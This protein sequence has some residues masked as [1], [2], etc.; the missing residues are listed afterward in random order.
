MQLYSTNDPS[1]RVEFA[2][3]VFQALPR[4]KGLYMPVVLEPLPEAFWR[5]LPDL[6]LPD[7]GYEITRHLLRG[8]LPDERIR[9]IVDAAI[10]FPA[11]LVRLDTGESDAPAR[12]ILELFHGPSMAFKDF[13]ARFMAGVMDELSRERGERLLILVATS[14]DTG[15]AVAAGFYGSDHI[16]VVIL[17][18]RGKVSDIQEAQLT[19]LGGNVTALRVDGTFDDCQ[20]LVKEAFVDTE[21]RREA[22]LSS[23]NSINILRLIPQSFYYVEAYRQWLAAGHAD[24]PVFAV[25]SGNFG[26]LTAGLLAERM[27]LPVA[28]FVAATNA[29]DTVP[30]YHADGEYAPRA[31]VRTISN[32][33][34]VGAPSNFARMSDLFGS[35]WNAFRGR[36]WATSFDD[37]A[38]EREMASVYSASERATGE[39][40]VLDPHT[41]V[42]TLAL[43]RY[44]ATEE[45][46]AGI[47][48]ATAHPGKFLPD[49]ERVLGRELALP[50]ALEE[51]R[52]RPRVVRDV[53]NDYKAVRAVV[54]ER[55]RAG[56]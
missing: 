15:G 29:N 13:G 43:A 37:V 48:L 52:M 30:R 41:A 23:A 3:A 45:R 50:P 5:Q 21:L 20:A 10:D 44:Q 46:R 26:N 39:G 47:V 24:P 32:A 12:Y 56:A 53:A 22:N 34:D 7:I 33:M 11:P 28:K 16:D 19:T 9:A 54:L 55:W 18:P 6:S 14:G 2:E 38:T 40:Y 25:P 49:V 35:T 31:S 51:V 42:G 4:D 17:Y 1:L 27:G 36:V 8:A